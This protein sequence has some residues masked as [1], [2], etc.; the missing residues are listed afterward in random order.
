MSQH[1]WLWHYTTHNILN[2]VMSV[3]LVYFSY[4]T[5]EFIITSGFYTAPR[6]KGQKHIPTKF[7]GKKESAYQLGI[8]EISCILYISKLFEVHMIINKS[9][10]VAFTN[11]ICIYTIK[12]NRCIT[13]RPGYDAGIL[14][15][16][17]MAKLFMM[18]DFS[19]WLWMKVISVPALHDKL[20]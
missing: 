13:K 15:R 19:F 11:F 2:G 14:L 16:N 6:L 5:Q 8:K 7:L 20:L 10:F 18:I 4:F 1:T 3:C 12:D 9:L 17:N